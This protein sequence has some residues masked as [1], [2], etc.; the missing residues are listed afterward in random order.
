M[1]GVSPNVLTVD[2]EEWF[3]VC[4]VGGPLAPD[5]WASLPSR[6]VATTDRLLD[7]LDHAGVRAT[8]FVLGYV[9][10]RHPR[11]IERIR[12][13]GHEIGSHGYMHDRVYML[14]A[15]AF[16]ADLD[17]SLSALAACGAPAVAGFRAPEWSINDRSLWA[18]PVLARK[19]F[20]FDSS[21]APMRVVG[22]P[23][24]AREPHRRDT[25]AGAIVECPPAVQRRLGQDMPF[26]GGWGLRMSRPRTVLRALEARARAGQVSV[27]WVHPWEI[28]DD[29]PVVRLPAAKH[30]AHYFRLNGF[31]D[32]LEAILRGATFGPLGPVALESRR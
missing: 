12:Q 17:R 20:Q 4:G 5:R 2:V 21:M 11:L 28:D 23:S 26:G 6:V 32:R 16:E 7:L 3:H 30:F 13:A 19:G 27:F 9:A 31:A 22:N 18:L 29:P 25:Q 14:T 8:F 24:Y 10:D 15:E 1:P